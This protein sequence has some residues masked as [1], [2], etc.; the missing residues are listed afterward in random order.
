[1]PS[2]PGLWHLVFELLAYTVGAQI[3]WRTRRRDPIDADRFAQVGVLVGLVLGAAI[4]AKI[5]YWLEHPQVAFADFPDAV[6]LLAGKSIVGGLL[7]GLIGVEWAKRWHGVRRSTGDALVWPLAI[8]ISIGR[9]GCHLGGLGD[10]THGNPSTLPWA[11]DHGDGIPRHPT[12]LYDIAWLIASATLL[13]WAHHQ[14]A[15][16]SGDRFKLFLAGYLAWRLLIDFLKPV[17]YAWWPGL[18]GIQWLCLA[19]LVYYCPH[20]IRIRRRWATR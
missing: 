2:S 19:G 17:P 10:G 4:G 6:N 5:A 13:A 9:I 16:A 18:S 15:F 1:M 14:R 11:V 8:G 20:L 7:G 3:Y 12:A